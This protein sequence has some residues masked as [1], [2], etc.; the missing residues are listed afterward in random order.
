MHKGGARSGPGLRIRPPDTW[1]TAAGIAESG[2]ALIAVGQT[3]PPLISPR[4]ELRRVA[5]EVG[6]VVVGEARMRSQHLGEQGRPEAFVQLAGEFEQVVEVEALG[7]GVD[8]DEVASLRSIEQCEEL[9]GCQLAWRVG[10]SDG[11]DRR[12]AERR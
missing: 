1:W 5:A 6:Q 7:Q 2:S 11:G 12:C 8:V 10:R 3:A 9:A 4:S